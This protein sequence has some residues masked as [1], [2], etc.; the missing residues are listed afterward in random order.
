MRPWVVVES[1]QF[2]EQPSYYF[3]FCVE[4]LQKVAEGVISFLPYKFSSDIPANNNM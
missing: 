3:R 4:V 1:S 2:L